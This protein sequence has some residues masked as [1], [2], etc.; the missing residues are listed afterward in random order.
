MTLALASLSPRQWL[1]G[2]ALACFAAVAVALLGQ[3][4]FDMRPCPWCILQ[5]FLFVLIGLICAI[6]A[7]V[8]ARPAH[9]A[10]ALTS[11]ALA[12]AG[13]AAALWQ[14]F[15]AARSD[16]CNLTLADK[17]INTLGLES[18]APLLFQVTASCADAAVSVLG[19]PF[20]F[21]SLA[22]FAALALAA[23]FSLRRGA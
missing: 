8:R 18:I 21:W 15:V 20:E 4:M 13:A 16:S 17:V 7:L 19:V 1:A 3:Q 2:M 10:T 5:R 14:H 6:G 9:L 12:L 23:V 11:V 22:L